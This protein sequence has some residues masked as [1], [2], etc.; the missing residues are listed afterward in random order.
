M[1]AAGVPGRASPRSSQGF[2]TLVAGTP[3]DADA[4][5]PGLPE[6]LGQKRV[7]QAIVRVKLTPDF[8]KELKP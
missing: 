3:G 2:R 6:T 8:L 1:V 5:R 7:E 4:G